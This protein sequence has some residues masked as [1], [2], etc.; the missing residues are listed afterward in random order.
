[1]EFYLDWHTLALLSFPNEVDK[2]RIIEPGCCGNSELLEI[3]WLRALGPLTKDGALLAGSEQPGF[4]Q[5]S[6]DSGQRFK[7]S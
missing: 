7:R 3:V 2:L 4:E 1:M 5:P 6:P